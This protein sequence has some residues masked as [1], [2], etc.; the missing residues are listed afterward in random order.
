MKGDHAC[1]R[2]DGQRRKWVYRVLK[3]MGVQVEWKVEMWG[4]VTGMI[5]GLGGYE[6][7]EDWIIG[8]MGMEDGHVCMIPMHV[9]SFRR[10]REK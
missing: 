2:I 9:W 5:D 4:V 6:K 8:E 7:K 3:E 10:A 1:M